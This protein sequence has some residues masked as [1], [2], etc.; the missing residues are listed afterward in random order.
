[1]LTNNPRKIVGLLGYDFEI[2]EQRAIETEVNEENRHY[3]QTK[4][5]KLGH[6]LW[7]C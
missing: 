4:R 1:M 7:H 6:T 2:V 3:K 5:N